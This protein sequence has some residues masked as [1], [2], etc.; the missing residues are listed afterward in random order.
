MMSQSTITLALLNKVTPKLKVVGD[1]NIKPLVER[2]FDP[3]IDSNYSN[4]HF[5]LGLCLKILFVFIALPFRVLKKPACCLYFIMLLFWANVLIT[6]HAQS[7]CS[8]VRN[9]WSSM[10]G[11]TASYPNS[12]GASCCATNGISCS[13]GYITYM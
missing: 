8:I 11:R 2:L 3:S 9:I 13:G 5:S 12:V 10:G 6:P 1:I 4:L 7:D